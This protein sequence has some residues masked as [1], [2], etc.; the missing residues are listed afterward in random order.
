MRF[1]PAL[2]SSRRRDKAREIMKESKR[3]RCAGMERQRW[4]R[5]KKKDVPWRLGER[6]GTE[7]PSATMRGR[8]EESRQPRSQTVKLCT[9]REERESHGTIGS[10]VPPFVRLARPHFCHLL[11]ET[12]CCL[13]SSTKYA[14]LRKSYGRE[15]HGNNVDWSNL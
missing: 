3:A 8:G 1:S 10:F 7:E 6:K 15:T 13:C 14:P 11:S 9:K 2:L 5:R 4:N 12:R